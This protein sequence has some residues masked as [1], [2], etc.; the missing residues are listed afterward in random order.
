VQL[1]QTIRML[2][3]AAGPTSGGVLDL[4]DVRWV[5]RRLAD[6]RAG[7]DELLGRLRA[8]LLTWEERGLLTV[9]EPA[10]A[11]DDAP[12]EASAVLA[13]AL[14]ELQIAAYASLSSAMALDRAEAAIT[15]L[16]FAS[17]PEATR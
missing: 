15:R 9:T 6:S 5:I 17:A 14:G 7:V 16:T 2:T 1:D 4:D 3:Y 10:A 11:P 8:R 13:V 12:T